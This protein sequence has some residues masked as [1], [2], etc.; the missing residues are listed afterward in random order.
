MQAV[1]VLAQLSVFRRMLTCALVCSRMLT[2]AG[3]GAVGAA[4]CVPTYAHVCSRMLTYA[5]GGAVAAAVCVPFSLPH[6][7]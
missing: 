2:Y 7:R 3:G 5:G 6:R 1:A 4:V